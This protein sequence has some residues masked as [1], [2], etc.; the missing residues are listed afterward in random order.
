MS[1]W[2]KWLLLGLLSVVFGVIVLGAPIVA[3]MAITTLT[4]FLL[5]ISGVLQFIAAFSAEGTGNRFLGWIMGLILAFL[6][7]SFLAHPLAGIVTLAT[8]VLILLAAGG[9]VRII[10]AFQMRGTQF[11]WPTLFSGIVS[12]GLAIYVWSTPG[13]TVAIL[14][15]LLGVEMLVNGFGLIFLSMHIKGGGRTHA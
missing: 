1:E 5:I 7:W 12:L 8:V 11:F 3:S 13:A 2:V 6:G 14:G 15:I 10:L 4:G 9:L